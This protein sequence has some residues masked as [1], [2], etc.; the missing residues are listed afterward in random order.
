M[1]DS[2]VDWSFAADDTVGGRISLARDACGLSLED[3]AGVVGVETET[4]RHWENDQI[5]LRHDRLDKV[6]GV[7]KVSL[8][9]LLSGAGKGPLAAA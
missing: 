4:W 3:A 7:L 2:R 8:A 6:A 1:Y 5:A 9:W